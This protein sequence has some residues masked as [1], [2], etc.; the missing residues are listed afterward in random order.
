MWSSST[1]PTTAPRA[2]AGWAARIRAAYASAAAA[3]RSDTSRCR[4]IWR[5]TVR[6]RPLP[7]TTSTST[8]TPAYQAVNWSRRR[9]SGSI[10][11][12]SRTEPVA[13]APQRRD[14]LGLE[15]VVDLAPQAPH[16]HLQHVG[17]GIVIV[18]PHV[19]RDRGAVEHLSR[20]GDEQLQQG[21][22]LRAEREEAVA[23]AHPAGGEIDLQVR[24]AMHGRRERGTPSCQRLEAREQLA[25]RE[26]L[27]EVV[28]RADLEPPDPVVHGIERRQ[29]EHLRGHALTPQLAAQL[30]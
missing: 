30:E 5:R 6:N 28:V 18:V 1:A 11:G 23:A 8:S 22:L 25:E 24:D 29:H 14:Q 21:E 15:P 16:Q 9:A 20:M 17:E 19:R 2:P 12:G 13:R 3:A 7:R 4:D 27:G 10:S 26:R